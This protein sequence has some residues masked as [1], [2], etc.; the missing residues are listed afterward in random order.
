VFRFS[1]DLAIDYPAARVWTY[2]VAFEQVPLWEHGVVE[3]RQVSQGPPGVGTQMFARRVYAGRETVLAGTIVAF[4][5]G[6]SATMKLHGGPLAEA[7]VEYAVEPIDGDRSIVTYTAQGSLIWPLRF[8]D[9]ILS[10]L[11]RAEARKNLLSLKRRIDAGISPRA[12]A[13]PAGAA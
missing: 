6:R 13:R 3:V 12:S 7:S 10:A 4:D 8:L 5:D 1:Q 11:G 9:P 2:L